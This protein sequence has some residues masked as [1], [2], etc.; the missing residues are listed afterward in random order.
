VYDRTSG[1]DVGA[2]V[3][4]HEI[5]TNKDVLSLYPVLAEGVKTIGSLQVRSRGTVGGN[6]CTAAPSADAVGPLLVLDAVCEIQG[7]SG[8]RT[9]PMAAFF[10][11]P[12]MT[13]L[14]D[15]EILTGIHIPCV[16]ETY[17]SSYYKYGRRNAMEIALQTITAYVEVGSDGKTCS[18]IRVALGT[19]A[20]TPIRA[21]M[22]EQYYLG[23]DLSDEAVIAGGG[24]VVLKEATPRSSWRSSAGFR[25]D[26]LLR[27]VPRTVKRA[28]E[29]IFEKGV[30]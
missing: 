20:P 26:L 10:T 18:R 11:G 4:H 14:Q 9:V 25:R 27:L 30:R 7:L 24:D 15:D 3:T 1:L 2:L 16:P 19:S 5:E 17:G 29:N 12:K 23:K 28:Y 6:I 22:T 21:S 13:V 8:R